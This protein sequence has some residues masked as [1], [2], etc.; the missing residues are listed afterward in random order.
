MRPQL[1]M[2]ALL[3]L[4]IG[5]S[6]LFLRSKPGDT[7]SVRVTERGIQEADES[8]AIVPLPENPSQRAFGPIPSE[9]EAAPPAAPAEAEDTAEK[10]RT[11]ATENEAADST[12]D[13]FDEALGSYRK[14]Q[15]KM[16]EEQ[17]DA[18]ANAGGPQAASASLYAAHSARNR[19]GCAE[20]A[21]KFDA[22]Q[23]ANPG[24]NVANEARWHA[25]MC[26]KEMGQV[27]RAR[28]HYEGLLEAL[29]YAERA[30]HALDRLDSETGA[31]VA[32]RRAAAAPDAEKA[33]AKSK[34][35]ADTAAAAKPAA[36]PKAN[37][38]AKP[39]AGF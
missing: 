34:A 5:S 3:I 31:A 2:A 8:V 36:K 19:A 16:A 20:A 26:Y 21:G 4:M 11:G 38:P 29:A 15:Y 12:A 37:T 27:D 13:P 25:A 32:S 39:G 24:T 33:G 18:I 28:A 22:V 6:F 1:A 30:R 9:A 17:F 7:D 35:A 23:Q 14:G 10:K